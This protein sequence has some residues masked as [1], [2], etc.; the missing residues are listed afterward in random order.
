MTFDLLFI[1]SQDLRGFPLVERR[2][3]LAALLKDEPY[4]GLWFSGE[5]AGSQGKALFRQRRILLRYCACRGKPR[6]VTMRIR[7]RP[8]PPGPEAEFMSIDGATAVLQAGCGGPW[9]A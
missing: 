3:M 6:N 1:G 8:P 7:K 9:R 4:D 2:A 5:V